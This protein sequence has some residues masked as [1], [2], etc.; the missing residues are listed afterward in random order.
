MKNPPG[1]VKI[2]TGGS[3]STTSVTIDGNPVMVSRAEIVIEPCNENQIKLSCYS[4]QANRSYEDGEMQTF[5]GISAENFEFFK[6]LMKI[7]SEIDDGAI[8]HELTP[9]FLDSMAVQNLL[10]FIKE[11]RKV[12][13]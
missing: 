3:A 13:T 2:S 6:G 12:P 7:V 8:E 5:Y 4:Q 10:L 1:L 9:G 11:A